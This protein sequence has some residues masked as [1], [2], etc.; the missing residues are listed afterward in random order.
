MENMPYIQT[1]IP[2]NEN[3]LNNKLNAKVKYVEDVTTALNEHDDRRVYELI[4]SKKYNEL[5]RGVEHADDNRSLASL[6]TDLQPDLSHHLADKL[7][8]YLAEAF[9]FFYYQESAL[10]VFEV[11]FGN[12]WDRAYFGRLDPINVQFKFKQ[13][14]YQKLVESVRLAAKGQRYHSAAIDELTKTNEELQQLVEKQGER[15][16]QRQNLENQLAQL[17]EKGGFFNRPSTEERDN[18]K[19]Q[20]SA[21][22]EDDEQAETVPDQIEKNNATILAYSK[23]DTILIYEQRA[24]NEK[25][26]SFDQF[27][28]AAKSLYVDYVKQLAAVAEGGQADA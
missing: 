2:D 4:N 23:E 8:Q 26:G 12:W 15:N 27:E 18:L 1:E 16:T 17:D 10:G 11:Y 25:F 28:A 24:I 19:M 7:I 6:V 13:E 22:D 14:E 21:L 9:P 5:I 20:L 3:V